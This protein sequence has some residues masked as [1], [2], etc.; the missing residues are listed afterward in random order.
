MN[1]E[2]I[3]YGKGAKIWLGFCMVVQALAGLFSITFNPV[4]GVLSILSAVCYGILLFKKNVYAFYGICGVQ[5]VG[6]IVNIIS[7]VAIPTALSGLINPLI[8]FFV[9]KKYFFNKQQ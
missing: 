4:I 1:Q 3:Q 7:S 2:T 5:A 8:T 6:V 9:I